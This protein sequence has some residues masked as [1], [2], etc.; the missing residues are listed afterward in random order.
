M[1]RHVVGELEKLG[2]QGQ[3]PLLGISRIIELGALDSDMRRRHRVVRVQ[4]G[5]GRIP[6]DGCRNLGM[7]ARSHA[8]DD[9][10][11]EAARLAALLRR[12]RRRP[13]ELLEEGLL[14]A[15][16]PAREGGRPQIPDA[17][18]PHRG[19]VVLV[20]LVP[21][22]VPLQRGV[23]SRRHP[24]LDIALEPAIGIGELAFLQ[25]QLA[26]LGIQ[27]AAA[28]LIE[29]H[30][31]VGPA[32]G[33]VQYPVLG[34]GFLDHL[35]R[36]IRHVV[37]GNLS[38]KHAFVQ[39]LDLF[40]RKAGLTHQ[41]LVEEEHSRFGVLGN[42]KAPSAA[43]RGSPER[44][45]YVAEELRVVVCEIGQVEEEARFGESADPLMRGVEDIGP[46]ADRVAPQQSLRIAVIPALI[47]L[48]EHGDRDTVVGAILLE[49]GV[50]ALCALQ[51]VARP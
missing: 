38:G 44:R 16:H 25:K 39:A 32:R 18:H 35:L 5:I 51:D 49:L 22:E 36:D 46:F 26:G 43:F 7:L 20:E 2:R 19:I 34:V 45:K 27:K 1:V 9:R 13:A 30:E 24:V 40:V 47:G 33:S 48:L 4:I 50:Q 14:V 15:R 21:D 41:V 17:V 23:V 3:R 11:G 28:V 37:E 10:V 42:R 31:V 8:V 12:R 29:D 6:H